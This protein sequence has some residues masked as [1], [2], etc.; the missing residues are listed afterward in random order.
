VAGSTFLRSWATF[1]RHA[2]HTECELVLPSTFPIAR[3][4]ACMTGGHTISRIGGCT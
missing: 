3:H 2:L 1:M 4:I